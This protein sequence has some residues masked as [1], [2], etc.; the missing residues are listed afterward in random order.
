MNEKM[1]KKRKIERD[2]IKILECKLN[3][4][5]TNYRYFEDDDSNGTFCQGFKTHRFTFSV[6][7]Y[8]HKND[9]Y[10]YVYCH[11]YEDEFSENN[12]LFKN[13]IFYGKI[14]SQN[15]TYKLIS[16]DCIFVIDDIINK[17]NDDL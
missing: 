16:K 14:I 13:D 2:F 15:I 11:I 17:I 7:N 6:I 10:L 4:K 8:G 5:N 3:N 1:N 9:I 12:Y